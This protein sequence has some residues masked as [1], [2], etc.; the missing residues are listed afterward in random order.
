MRREISEND[1]WEGFSWLLLR[2]KRTFQLV[3]VWGKEFLKLYC[4]SWFSHWQAISVDIDGATCVSEFGWSV[5]FQSRV[6]L[7]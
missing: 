6:G 3:K 4:V 2:C 1:T 5:I 7:I